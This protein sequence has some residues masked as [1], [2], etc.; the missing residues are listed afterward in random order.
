MNETQTREKTI[1]WQDTK[2]AL[3][4]LPTLSGLDYLRAMMARKVPGPPIA[5]VMQ[6]DLVERRVSD[7]RVHSRRVTLQPHRQ[8]ARRLCVHRARFGA[9]LRSA[10]HPARRRGLY[11]DRDQGQLP[12]ADHA[13][14]GTAASHW[15][16]HEGGQPG[17]LRRRGAARREWQNRRDRDR[18]T[19]GLLDARKFVARSHTGGAAGE[20]VPVWLGRYGYADAEDLPSAADMNLT[21]FGSTITSA[22]R[23]GRT[24]CKPSRERTRLSATYVW[25]AVNARGPKSTTA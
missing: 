10:H 2:P 9:R 21:T 19:A 14:L 17:G 8:R 25:P 22:G 20:S 16:G 4:V 6:M 23:S 5:S 1:S 3:D 7:V 15:H 12:S 11:L 13:E 18:F 24:R